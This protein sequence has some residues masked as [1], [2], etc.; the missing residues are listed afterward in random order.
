MGGAVDL[1][2]ASELD[3]AGLGRPMGHVNLNQLQPDALQRGFFRPVK[4]LLT[5]LEKTG[6]ADPSIYSAKRFFGTIYQSFLF[7]KLGYRVHLRGYYKPGPQ[8]SLRFLLWAMNRY[9][10]VKPGARERHPAVFTGQVAAACLGGVL[11]TV[12]SPFIL[13]V[14]VLTLGFALLILFGASLGPDSGEV[15][16]RN[17]LRI[18]GEIERAAASGGAHTRDEVLELLRRRRQ[19]E[20]AA[21]GWDWTT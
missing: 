20:V 12:A 8:G 11:L 9:S 21:P 14:G 7:N 16:R 18:E 2:G 10:A 13:A 4:P 19:Y 3:P 17:L 5:P 15:R 6:E 1:V